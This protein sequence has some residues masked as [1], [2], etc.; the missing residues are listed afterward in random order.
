[1]KRSTII[2]LGCLLAGVALGWFFHQSPHI[3]NMI[4]QDNAQ[5]VHFVSPSVDVATISNNGGQTTV[6]MSNGDHFFLN[7]QEM[8][9]SPTVHAAHCT[10]PNMRAAFPVSNCTGE[11]FVFSITWSKVTIKKP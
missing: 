9:Y 4:T 10:V 2:S 11:D 3:V 6:T 5:T 8:S 1:M 7:G